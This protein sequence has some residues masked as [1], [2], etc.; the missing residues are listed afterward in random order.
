MMFYTRSCFGVN[1]NEPGLKLYLRIL[2]LKIYL[3]PSATVYAKTG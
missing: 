2:A 1:L 3:S